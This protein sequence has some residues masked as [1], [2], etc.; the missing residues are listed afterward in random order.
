M[1]KIKTLRLFFG[2][3]LGIYFITDYLRTDGKMST[4]SFI[5]ITVICFIGLLT[6][7]YLNNKSKL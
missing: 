3:L 1:S 7:L 4:V 5:I 6:D 2:L